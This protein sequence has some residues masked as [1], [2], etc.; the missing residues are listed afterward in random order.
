MI[1]DSASVLAPARFIDGPRVPILRE[2]NG[3]GLGVLSAQLGHAVEPDG[4]KFR[5]NTPGFAMSQGR[6]RLSLEVDI[7]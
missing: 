3:P 1:Q 4:R 2:R 5:E 7:S 6:E